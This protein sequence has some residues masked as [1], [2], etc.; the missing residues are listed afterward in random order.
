MVLTFVYIFLL[1]L[2]LSL[3][4]MPVLIKS[5][6]A[7]GLVDDPVNNERK[8]HSTVTP[9]SGGIGIVLAS[10]IAVL[11]VLPINDSLLGFVFASLVIIGF[12]LLDDFR[13]LSP[14][15]KLAG[16]TLGVVI[17]MANGMVLPEI[18]FF[19]DAPQWVLL[20]I[21]FVFVLGV[22]NGVN[23]SDG[24]DG[25]AAGTTLMAL[26]LL[27]VLA[28]ESNADAVLAISLAILASLLGFLR[29]NTHPAR[30]FMGDSGSQFL[31]FSLAWLSISVTQGES[32]LSFSSLLP[33]LVL[34]I[35]V[36][37]ILQ[38]IPVRI[39][40]GL[41]LP[42][43]DKEHFHH[44]IAKLGLRQY[45]VVATIYLLQA[46]LLVSAYMLR[47]ASH[48]VVLGF[49]ILYVSIVLGTLYLAN[50]YNW[51]AKDGIDERGYKQRNE[52]FRT[53]GKLHPYTG[54]FFGSVAVLVL[55]FSALFSENLPH[56]FVISSLVVA[57]F[58][59]CFVLF[60]GDRFPLA[61]SRVPSYVATILLLWSLSQSGI[62]HWTSHAI[63]IFFALVA[64]ALLLAVRITRKDYF[65]LTTFD[66]LVLI[67]WVTLTPVFLL[68]FGGVT[69]ALSLAFRICVM[70]YVCEYVL[71]RGDLARRRL[72][73]CSTAAIFL[74]GLQL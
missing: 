66:L 67:S 15:Q 17:A 8:I 58:L 23:F 46:I 22:I 73:L 59:M 49:Y 37:D 12:G 50:V 21:T 14:A 31:G 11:V 28:V 24:M 4:F 19:P 65:A 51:R 43:P 63:D 70:L 57:S 48:Q 72:G 9:R 64:L 71:A 25:L 40:K 42:G 54:K 34:G 68:D 5:S 38:V 30:I 44:Q 60:L 6:V 47:H 27:L 7:W 35:P 1:A 3:V 53:L 36:M 10:A 56:Y 74:L 61:A 33:L 69:N 2:L 29:F 62:D 18:P 55:A 26:V 16:Q 20:G 52:F 45:Q 32:G 41:P 13:E 39:R